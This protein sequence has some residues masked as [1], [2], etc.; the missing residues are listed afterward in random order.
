MPRLAW[1]SYQ[2]GVL[3]AIEAVDAYR[4]RMAKAAAEPHP[5][6]GQQNTVALC[7]LDAAE[8]LL[9]SLRGLLLEG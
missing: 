4:S 1:T 3:D 8:S 2:R 6:T 5:M 7:K 9:A